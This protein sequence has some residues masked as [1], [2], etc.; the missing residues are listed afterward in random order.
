MPGTIFG[1]A[2]ELTKAKPAWFENI[3]AELGYKKHQVL[4]IRFLP[5]SVTVVYED[6]PVLSRNVHKI[7]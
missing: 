6:G 3:C 2:T 1:S 4:S 7:G 5:D